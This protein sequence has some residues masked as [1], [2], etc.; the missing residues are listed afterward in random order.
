M[1]ISSVG[2]LLTALV[3]GAAACGGDSDEAA[4]PATAQYF[5]VAVFADDSGSTYAQGIARG[6]RD[7]AA[8][9]GVV[10]DFFDARMVPEEQVQQM[11]DAMTSGQYIGGFV[12]PVKPDP[13]CDVGTNFAPDHNFMLAVTTTP[14]CGRPATNGDEAWAPGTL[15]FV[16][17]SRY[18]QA[19][20]ATAVQAL[21]DARVGRTP[22]ARFYAAPGEY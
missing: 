22:I 18:P 16:S 7:R 8:E 13:L 6:A 11:R 5:R 19:V 21:Y 17:A 1:R 12:V 10:L 3:F 15:T 4:N 2:A 20:G 14:I 9:L